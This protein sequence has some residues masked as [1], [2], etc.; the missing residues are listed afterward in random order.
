K[1]IYAKLDETD[2]FA[3]KLREKMGPDFTIEPERRVSCS[4]GIATAD[5]FTMDSINQAMKRADDALYSVKKTT[6]RNYRV[7]TPELSESR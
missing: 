5:E 3:D 6:K 4:I 1:M 2:G 7:W